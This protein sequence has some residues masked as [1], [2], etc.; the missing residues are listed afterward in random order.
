MCGTRGRRRKIV[1]ARARKKTEWYKNGTADGKRKMQFTSLLNQQ[2]GKSSILFLVCSFHPAD[3]IIIP[4]EPADSKTTFVQCK[5]NTHSKDLYWPILFA[6]VPVSECRL[7]RLQHSRE[8]HYC[9]SNCAIPFQL[10][11]VY[12][13]GIWFHRRR[14]K[15]HDDETRRG[16]NSVSVCK[17]GSMFI[18][19]AASSFRTAP[20]P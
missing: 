3:S 19:P 16:K 13:A 8:R 18:V 17:C 11:Y 9:H 14:I 4:R 12:S 15:M 7:K 20:M 5:T 1:S 2:T 10:F 6:Y